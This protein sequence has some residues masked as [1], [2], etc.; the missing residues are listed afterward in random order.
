MPASHPATAPIANIINKLVIS[1][2]FTSTLPFYLKTSDSVGNAPDKA[3]L[4][5][6]CIGFY[7]ASSEPDCRM[8]KA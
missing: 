4:R 7:I 1:I 3:L 2:V 8:G 5:V 6:P